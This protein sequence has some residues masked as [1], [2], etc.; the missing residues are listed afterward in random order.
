MNL[1]G[2]E[3]RRFWARRA[4][5]VVLLLTAVLV[6]LLAASAAWSTRPAT[7]AEMTAAQAQVD[8][9]GD[10]WKQ[11]V[12]RC[13]QS[14]TEYLGPD[15]TGDQCEQVIRPRA[16]D[17]V[18]RTPLDLRNELDARGLGLVV[19]LM[20]A[21]IV[22]AATFSGADWSSGAMGTQLVFEPRRL[23]V[24]VAKGAA[25]VLSVTLAAAVLTA[26]FWGALLAVAGSR[27]IDVPGEVVTAILQQSARGLVVVAAAAL[28]THALTMLLRST[29]GAL[30]LLFGYAVAGEVVVASLPFDK[31]SQWSL[32]NNV[33]AWIGNGVQIYDES[34]CPRA[35]AASGSCS[36]TYVLGATHGAAYLA[37]L[38]A[39]VVLLSPPVF[40][41]RD[42]D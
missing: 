14:P 11:E 27:G 6:G 21:A 18:G 25:V 22:L 36:P 2:A 37:V 29:V 16:E 34:I 40:R 35:V 32:A 15:A 9:M 10:S 1:V 39:V 30:G 5:V 4:V 7:Q 38:L 42:L 28:G 17:Y 31:V 23:R 13:E 3:L 12:R 41:R 8:Q 20:G 19:V 24:W 26:A 33:Q